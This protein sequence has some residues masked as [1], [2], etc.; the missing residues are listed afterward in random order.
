MGELTATIAHE[1][2][3]PLFA[4]LIDVETSLRMLDETKPDVSLL[5][6]SLSA[7][8]AGGRRATEII[9]RIRSLARSEEQPKTILDLNAIIKFSIKFLEPELCRN[10]VR[11]ST[12]LENE[13]PPILGNEIELQQVVMNL[14]NNGIQALSVVDVASR[15]LLIT[16]IF[17]GDCVEMS[18]CDHGVGL[19]ES[20]ITNIFEPFYTT[21]RGGMGMGLAISRTIV[22]AHGGRIWAA[23]NVERGAIFHLHLPIC[24]QTNTRQKHGA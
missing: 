9:D 6:D 8:L 21:K 24:E 22:R 4:I 2:K 10:S 18:I 13:L 23:N 14:I 1:V 19:D 12:Q 20:A 3:Q 5:R 7:I 17:A 15:V 11:I 16:T